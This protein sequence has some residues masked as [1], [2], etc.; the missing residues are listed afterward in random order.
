MKRTTRGMVC[1]ALALTLGMWLVARSSGADDD[2]PEPVPEDVRA[3]ILKIADL[4]EK[5]KI[6]DAR[7]EAA[8]FAKKK[9]YDGGDPGSCKLLMRAFQ[10]RA[11]KGFGVGDKPGLIKPDGIE[12]YVIELGDENKKLSD[13]TLKTQAADIKKIAYISAAIGDISLESAPKKDSPDG[14]KKVKDWLRWS[15]E[16]HD[17]GLKLA[18]AV[19]KDKLDPKTVKIAARN[20]D[21]SCTECHA[22]FR[23]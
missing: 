7:K 20:L 2:D 16:M 17:Y 13:K 18:E 10:L 11:K 14:K 6:E 15:Q 23:K 1:G 21:G 4:L 12:K 3:A 8:A 19:G 5:G 22:P 9:K